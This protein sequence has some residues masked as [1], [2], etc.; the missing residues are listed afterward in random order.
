MWC[1]NQ[2]F[3][4]LK[5]LNV[6]HFINIQVFWREFFFTKNKEVGVAIY[7][8]SELNKSVKYIH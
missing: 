6:D 8:N 4:M 5:K 3:F 2:T 1:E 7:H